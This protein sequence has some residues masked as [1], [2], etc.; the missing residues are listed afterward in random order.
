MYISDGIAYA[1]EKKP[2][3]KV[4]GVR[5]MKDFVLWVRF[6][7]GEAKV[8]DFK[9]LLDAP[10]FLPLRD[11]QLFREVYIDYGVTVW[12]DGDIDISPSY[13]YEHGISADAWSA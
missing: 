8:F 1:G 9:P 7:T 3:V 13:L 11:E 5:P 6:N 4:C 12:A 2:P 10:A